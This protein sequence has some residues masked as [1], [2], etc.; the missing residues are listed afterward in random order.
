[1]AKKLIDMKVTKSKFT[2]SKCLEVFGL[3]IMEK[4]FQDKRAIVKAV[5]NY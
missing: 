5:N 3:E 1:M 2:A 4:I